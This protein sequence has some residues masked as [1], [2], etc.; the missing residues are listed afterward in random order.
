M[1]DS[2]TKNLMSTGDPIGMAKSYGN[3]MVTYMDYIKTMDDLYKMG[4]VN[5]ENVSLYFSNMN[6]K[7]SLDFWSLVHG[8]M[9]DGPSAGEVPT[10]IK[11][12]EKS[13]GVKNYSSYNEILEHLNKL[14]GITEENL[15][16][17]FKKSRS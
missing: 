17:Y 4:G 12:I 5:A 14:G 10:L 1:V 13:I 11:S 15:N 6:P 2:T 3:G 7:M 16:L 9:V 8:F